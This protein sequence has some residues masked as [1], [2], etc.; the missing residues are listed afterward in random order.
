[1]RED[2]SKLL[3]ERSRRAGYRY[4]AN[5]KRA[6]ERILP[7]Q[8]YDEWASGGKVSIR[9]HFSGKSRKLKN[10]NENLAPLIG[11]LTKSCGRKWDDVFSEISKT[12]PHDSAVNAH[13]YQHLFQFVELNPGFDPVT[14]LVLKA[15]H[16]HYYGSGGPVGNAIMSTGNNRNFYVDAKGFLRLAPQR[17]GLMKKFRV[18]KEPKREP[19]EVRVS[20]E[21]WAV[22]LNDG[23][24]FWANLRPLPDLTFYSTQMAHADGTVSIFKTP[25]FLPF[26]DEYIRHHKRQGPSHVESRFSPSNYSKVDRAEQASNWLKNQYVKYYGSAVYC[27]SLMQMNS[28]DIRQFILR[29]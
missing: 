2:F 9:K 3:C 26:N 1:M 29:K 11:F 25:A 5:Y 17:K 19:Y 15:Q 8:N 23:I 16:R 21:R 12:C 7:H 13:V 14:G 27:H 6:D 18:D 20:K 28:R 24:W 22:C 10:L 4:G